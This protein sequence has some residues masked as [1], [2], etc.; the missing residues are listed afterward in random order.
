M[1]F[2]RPKLAGDLMTSTLHSSLQ[3]TFFQSSTVQSLCSRAHSNHL[4]ACSSVNSG[5]SAALH[6]LMCALA[7]TRLSS[8]RGVWGHE[9]GYVLESLSPIR[10]GLANQPSGLSWGNNW[11]SAASFAF[12]RTLFSPSIVDIFLLSSLSNRQSLQ[13]G[14]NCASFFLNQLFDLAERL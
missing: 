9:V 3:M 1:V 13:S 6:F 8:N 5:R 14:E 7:K 2:G 10:F 4:C 11:G 12:C